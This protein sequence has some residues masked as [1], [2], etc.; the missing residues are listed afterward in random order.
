[1]NQRFFVYKL[2]GDKKRK[3][4]VVRVKNIGLNDMLANGETPTSRFRQVGGRKIKPQYFLEVFHLHLD[5][6]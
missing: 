1:M 5:M 3:K 6:V 4:G 2:D